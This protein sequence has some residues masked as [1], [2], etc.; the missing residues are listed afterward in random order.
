MRKPDK[1]RDWELVLLSILGLGA[2]AMWA[3]TIMGGV[4]FAFGPV[5]QLFWDFR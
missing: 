1:T 5:P 2:L 3:L 4:P